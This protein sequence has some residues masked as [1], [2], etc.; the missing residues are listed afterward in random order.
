MMYICIYLSI[1]REK[2]KDN[3]LHGYSFTSNYIVL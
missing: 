1:E 3:L 2:D